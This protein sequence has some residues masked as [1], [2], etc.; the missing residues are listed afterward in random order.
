MTLM[1]NWYLDRLSAMS[2]GEIP[3]RLRQ[4]VQRKYEEHFCAGRKQ[5]GIQIPSTGKILEIQIKATKIIPAEIDIFGKILNYSQKEIKWHC[6]IFSGESFPLI[7]SKKIN[8]RNNPDLSAKN[9]WE[10]NR[11]QFLT[12]ISLNYHQTGDTLY[13]DQFIRIMDSWIIENPY[14]IGINWYSNIEIN[15]RLINWFFCWE[16]L[17][18]NKLAG[19]NPVF[20]KFVSEKWIPS[21][22]QHCKYSYSNPSRFSSANNHLISEYSGL[23][24]ASSLWKFKESGLWLEYSQK[25]LEREI[26]KQHSEGINK[27]EAAEYIQFIT[28]FFLLPCVVGEKTKYAF[29]EIYSRT[30]KMIFEYILEFIDIRGNYPVYGDGDDGKVVC[31]A[32]DSNFNNFI[33]LLTSASVLYKDH[34]FKLKMTSFD[35]KNEI[36]FGNKGRE[37]FDSLKE[38]TENRKSAFY[39]Y[40]GHFIF[41]NQKEGKEIYLH[42]N[43]A[44]LGY[45]SLAAHGHADALSIIMN[46]NGCQIIVDPGTYC[47]HVAKKW[48]NYFVSTMAHSTIC[49][50]G[51]NQA[52]HAGDTIWLNHYKCHAL[53]VKSNGTH[54]SVSAEHNGYRRTKHLREVLFNKYERTFTI[55]DDLTMSD[56]LDRECILLYHLHPDIR[57]DKVASNIFSL[58]HQTGIRLSVT[59]QD[60]PDC[61]IINGREDP[62]L[63]WYSDS[64]MQKMPTNVLYAKRTI[65]KSFKSV[66]KILI[67]EY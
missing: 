14:L 50:D 15:I 54:E 27:E 17:D 9:V 56:D 38:N 39:K 41:R 48:R 49:I 67:N 61:S 23:F 34:R 5:P 13:L 12:H 28:D 58:A 44:P 47:Y 25:G 19:L 46:I 59:I 64:F 62:V 66:T 55:N 42:F 60:F 53:S 30:L 40:E 52:D 24:I 4:L 57:V 45:L 22:Y 7:F 63:G 31:L 26:V 36:L 3:Y 29:S 35:L 37:T 10:I 20:G 32:P 51:R 21:I 1:S 2:A 65:N 8:I 11:L 33:S 6:D 43:A 18:V 16:I